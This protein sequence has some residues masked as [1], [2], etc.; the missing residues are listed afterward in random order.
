ML[1][2]W[3]LFG[4]ILKNYIIYLNMS[5][6]PFLMFSVLFYTIRCPNQLKATIR[7]QEGPEEIIILQYAFLFTRR[8]ILVGLCACCGMGKGARKKALRQQWLKQ[9]K[10][11]SIVNLRLATNTLPN[12]YSSIDTS[13]KEQ[14][15][16]ARDSSLLIKTCFALKMHWNFADWMSETS[17][18]RTLWRVFWAKSL[19][20]WF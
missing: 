9:R 14:P 7:N 5:N 19:Q 1:A 11:N 15:V 17:L 12:N 6:F 18:T 4:L 8:R 10:C 2:A 3:L 20:I 13:T 16:F